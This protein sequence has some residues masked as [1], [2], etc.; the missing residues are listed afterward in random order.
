M[1]INVP[2]VKKQKA[3]IYREKYYFFPSVKYSEKYSDL[4]VLDR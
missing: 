2:F 3:F 1:Q 4:L